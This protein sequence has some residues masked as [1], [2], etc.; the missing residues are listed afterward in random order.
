MASKKNKKVTS[1]DYYFEIENQNKTF[2]VLE[3]LLYLD[4][5]IEVIHHKEESPVF[6]IIIIIFFALLFLGVIGLSIYIIRKS[7]RGTKSKYIDYQK[8]EPSPL[9]PPNQHYNSAHQIPPEI[10]NSNETGYSS[11][12]NQQ[13][14]YSS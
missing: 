6:I 5:D 14:G 4:Y 7:N 1:I 3:N 13:N 9:Y 2:L 8:E 12:I 10:V 11:G